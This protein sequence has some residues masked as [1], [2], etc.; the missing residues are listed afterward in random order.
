MSRG[1]SAG[2]IAAAAGPTT[3]QALVF[4]ALFD[5]GALRGSLCGIDLVIGG[6]S[7]PAVNKIESIEALSESTDSTE[8]LR[9]QFA[10]LDAGILAII[11]AE[12]YRGRTANLYKVFL[13]PAAGYAQ[14]D[15]PILHFPGRLIDIRSSEQ[16]GSC[17]V[18]VLVEHFEAEL[19]RPR[20]T[21]YNDAD[22]RRLYPTDAGCEHVEQMTEVSL[23]WPTRE[24]LKA[25]G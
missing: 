24:A 4:E 2:Q 5:S 6:N 22:Q 18:T 10:G 13:D 25:G 20:V 17:G 3:V 8:G 23:T 1:L 12:Q 7:Y 9:V 11:A 15:S 14:V 21:R 16:G 19:R